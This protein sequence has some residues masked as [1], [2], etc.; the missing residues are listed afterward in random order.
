MEMCFVKTTRILWWFEEKLVRVKVDFFLLANNQKNREGNCAS[1]RRGLCWQQ[2][3]FQAT[4]SL[5]AAG[6]AA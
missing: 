3:R 1:K 6:I 5:Q 2:N 4:K